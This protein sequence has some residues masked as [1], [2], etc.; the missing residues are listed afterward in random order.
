MK[1]IVSSSSSISK[2]RHDESKRRWRGGR[3]SVRSMSGICSSFT[4]CDLILM[5]EITISAVCLCL[6]AF[7]C[8][9][10]YLF[11]GVFVSAADALLS[12]HAPPGTSESSPLDTPCHSWSP[13]TVD[14]NTRKS[15]DGV[16][17][18]FKYLTWNRHNL[19]LLWQEII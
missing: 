7:L 6:S 8:Q 12:S 13:K 10:G 1:Q 14:T 15:T 16:K 2:K 5:L 4:P 3:E 19:Q 9:V 17:L 11:A 18:T